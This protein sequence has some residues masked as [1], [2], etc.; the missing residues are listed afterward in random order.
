M[1]SLD[2]ASGLDD[3]L[4]LRGYEPGYPWQKFERGV[5]T[6]A[7]STFMI[8]LGGKGKRFSAYVGVDD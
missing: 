8:D 1:I 6:H 5:G 4:R 3:E 2:P 7:I